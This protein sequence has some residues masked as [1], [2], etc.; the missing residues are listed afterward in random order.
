MASAQTVA[1]TPPQGPTNVEKIQ[2]LPW[3][4]AANAANTFFVQFTFFGSVFVLFLNELGLSKGQVG[5][6]LSLLPFSGLIS[7]VVAPWVARVGYKRT[8][9]TFWT[10]RSIA[11][12][13]MLAIPWVIGR[14]GEDP[15]LIFIS[16]TVAAFAL[17][18]S[19]G[20]TANLP[21]VQEFVP[22]SVRGKYTATSNV[23]TSLA[24]FVAIFGGSYVLS[25]MPGL[26]GFILLIGFGVISGFISVWLSA[27]IPGGAPEPARVSEKQH[28][29]LT[30]ALRDP[31]FL[32]YL[33]GVAILTLATVPLASFV[34]LFMQE[35][36]G[37]AQSSIVLLQIGTLAGG[38]LS[39]YMW[40]WVADRYGSKPIMLWGLL[41][42]LSLP[43]LWLGM[44]QNSEVSLYFAAGIALFQG[45]ADMGW[46]IGSARLLY[47]SV[48]PT[49]KRSD[50]MALYNAWTGIAGGISQ[51]V[52]GQILAFTLA[53]GLSGQFWIFEINAY[54]PLFALGIVLPLLSI[55]IMNSIRAEETLGIGEF[56]GIFF[57]GNPFLAMTSM[58]R[59][60]LARSE[61]DTVRVTERMGEA[62]SP[63]AVDELLE[64]LKDPRF[65]VR[66]EAIVSISRMPSEPRLRDALIEI[67]HGSELA[68]SVVAAWA[69]GR[70]GDSEAYEPLREALHSEYR[71]IQAHS[72]RALGALGN[73]EIV[74]VLLER[75][76]TEPDKGLQMAYASALG[77]LQAG[78]A[79]PILL[80][81]LAK[82][83]NEGARMELAL[84]LARIVGDEHHFIQLLR[85]VRAD[86]GT[87][88]A[89]EINNLKR[90]LTRDDG[91]GG[92]L[93]ARCNE[94]ADLFARAALDE[95]A[96]CLSRLLTALPLDSYELASRQILQECAARLD[97]FGEHHREYIIL[98]L[99]TLLVTRH[100]H[101][102]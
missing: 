63:L 22:N 61:E 35:E 37:L 40:G 46:G 26:N 12:S 96:H 32:R 69:L 87:A 42:R 98:T 81:L 41:L 84:T 28:R 57:R 23:F 92:P 3:S 72:A 18:R 67:L 31:S 59:Y 45:I 56:A 30:V 5:F 65:N 85:S 80:D 39:S 70:M 102:G 75:L 78:E 64:V 47:V 52:G 2:K 74:P 17:L 15:T 25:Q 66:F 29:D 6:V 79:T 58:I 77:N 55:V 21:W 82:T 14:F 99:H 89:Q 83:N 71:S 10:L 4:I 49:E 43:L 68:L 86:A 13:F 91:K 7:L 34:P 51:I 76:I 54:F 19:V 88:I 50:Y 73:R 100:E 97:E 60:N 9:L 27:Y 20:M 53:L 94:C 38:L 44:P 95:G 90:K 16:C 11:A 48:V 93:I 1:V 8:Y 24:G 33:F 101:K 62:R 36:V